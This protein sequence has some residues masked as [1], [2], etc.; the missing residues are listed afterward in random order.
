[1]GF[2]RYSRQATHQIRWGDILAATV[3]AHTVG[4]AIGCIATLTPPMIFVKAA[5]GPEMLLA[6]AISDAVMLPVTV[7]AARVCVRSG[8]IG[9]GASWIAGAALGFLAAAPWALFEIAFMISWTGG[10]RGPTVEEVFLRAWIGVPIGMIASTIFW[11]VLRGAQPGA[12]KEDPLSRRPFAVLVYIPVVLAVPLLAALPEIIEEIRSDAQN[13]RNARMRDAIQAITLEGD[14]SQAAAEGQ[15]AFRDHVKWLQHE[16]RI[17]TGRKESATATAY[18]GRQLMKWGEVQAARRTLVQS[19]DGGTPANLPLVILARSGDLSGMHLV[20]LRA[21][22]SSQKPC[23]TRLEVLLSN[24]NLEPDHARDLLA[25]RET[26]EIVKLWQEDRLGQTLAS[27]VTDDSENNLIS[28]LGD[29]PAG[30]FRADALMDIVEELAKLKR[31]DA[32]AD[33]FTLA[34]VQCACETKHTDILRARMAVV[35]ITE[36]DTTRAAAIVQS[37]S[38]PDL[39]TRLSLRVEGLR[40]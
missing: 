40:Y 34:L 7:F 24:W 19:L 38:D 17:A 16:S 20:C 18:L 28:R 6:I 5:Y 11:F 3:V 30:L 10:T 26:S 4:I 32:A 21:S 36:R 25:A 12:F 31:P 27:E 23:F 9:I 8:Y 14:W 35:W 39:K 2:F 37:V 22:A 15:D 29:I 1:M 13:H 33:V